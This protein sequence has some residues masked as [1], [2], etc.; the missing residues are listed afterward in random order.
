MLNL[1]MTELDSFYFSLNKLVSL[2]LRITC[3]HGGEG[4]QWIYFIIP[5]SNLAVIQFPIIFRSR[6]REEGLAC[7]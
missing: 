6:E 4:Y 7:N 3:F 2:L 5:N 1:A